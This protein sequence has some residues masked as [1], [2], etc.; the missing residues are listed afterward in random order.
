M[1]R[2]PPAPLVARLQEIGRQIGAR[3]AA[4]RD[5]LETAREVA[6]RLRA[7][8][9]EAIEGFH[10]GAKDAG[11]PHLRIDVGESCLD[12]KHAR[13]VQFELCRGRYKALVTV[14]SRGDVTL[15]G[16][17]RQGK[18]EGPCRTF[19]FGAEAEID[20]ALGDFLERFLEEASAP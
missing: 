15:V 16:P 14:K 17:F 1:A 3:E 4:H 2:Q 6:D 9:A 20:A 7:R 13:A 11:A 19:P 12:H 18:A 8:V 10:A 5:A